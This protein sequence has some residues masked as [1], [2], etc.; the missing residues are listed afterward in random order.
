MKNILAFALFLTLG[1]SYA[2]NTSPCSSPEKRHFD[3]WVG[4]WHVFDTL[5]NKIGENRIQIIEGGCALQENW[6]GASGSNGTSLNYFDAA[7][8]TWNQL[9]LDN[10]GGILK[11]KGKIE[12][13]GLLKMSSQPN[14]GQYNQITWT[15]LDNGN[16]SQKWDI[17]T[18]DDDLLQTIFLGIYKRQ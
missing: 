8:S 11:L 4:E 18:A 9:W 6:T 13:S 7:D 14:N 12:E 17:F 16:V 10:Q 5:D 15:L 3:F 1:V 2:Q